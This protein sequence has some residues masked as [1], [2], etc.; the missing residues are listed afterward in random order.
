MSHLSIHFPSNLGDEDETKVYYIGLRGEFFEAARTGVVNAVYESR[1]MMK[2]HKQGRNS[3]EKFK[4]DFQ[5][6]NHLRFYFDSGT[7]LNYQMFEL[8]LS[9]GN[10]K[11]ELKI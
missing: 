8:F 3:I 2:D 11:P 1:P 9:F 4:L 7:G 6:I 10:L 5:L